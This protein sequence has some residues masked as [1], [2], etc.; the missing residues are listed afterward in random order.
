MHFKHVHPGK[1]SD[2]ESYSESGSESNSE[3]NPDSDHSEA[4]SETS[5][6]DETASNEPRLPYYELGGHPLPC[7]VAR[8]GSKLFKTRAAS[9]YYPLLCRFLSGV[10]H[11]I[12]HHC[13]GVNIDEALCSGDLMCVHEDLRGNMQHSLHTSR[14]QC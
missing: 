1:V 6:S 7:S 4:D 11:A 10:Y 3:S 13:I 5:D 12:K 9:V 2:S 8:C 14:C